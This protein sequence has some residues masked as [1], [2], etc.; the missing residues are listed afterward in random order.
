MV[1]YATRLAGDPAA[2]YRTIDVASRTAAADPHQLVEML[3]DEAVRALTSAA[4]AIENRDFRLK[5][6]RVTRATA[7]F[8][9]LENGL[10]HEKGGDVARTLGTLYRGLREQVVEASLGSDPTPF[11]EAAQTLS[12]IAAAWASMRPA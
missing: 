6:E 1:R 8:F 11:R 4:W 3:Y 2:T 10:D 5:A 12:E 7:I 9:A